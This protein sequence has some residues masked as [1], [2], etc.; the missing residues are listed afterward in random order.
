MRIAVLLTPNY[1][2]SRQDLSTGEKTTPDQ[3]HQGSYLVFA[4]DL[5][6]PTGTIH[7]V[8]TP[9]PMCALH[10]Y[11]ASRSFCT[12]CS[13]TT[14]SLMART[15]FLWYKPVTKSLACLADPT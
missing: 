9:E 6:E 10:D 3:S 12:A 4:G 14:E 15:G 13:P 5:P 1:Q 7:S 8:Y 11:W 2:K